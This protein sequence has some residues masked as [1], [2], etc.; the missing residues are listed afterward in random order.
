[1]TRWHIFLTMSLVFALALAFGQAAPLQASSYDGIPASD[2]D[3]QS[4]SSE[5]EPEGDG[6]VVEPDGG[7]NQD[8][9]YDPDAG[10]W[11]KFFTIPMSVA[12]GQIFT[13]TEKLHVGGGPL[14]I[15]PAWY[16]YHEEILTPGWTWN[17]MGPNNEPWGFTASDW[18]Y[19][20]V[21]KIPYGNTK[22]DWTFTPPLPVCTNLTITKYLVYNGPD[23]P[24]GQIIIA[25]YPTVPEP[26]T[27][28]L[29][30][31]AGL[32]LLLFAWR[33]RK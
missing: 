30:A 32:G 3:G 33:R 22:V 5:Y 26:G 31:T 20:W 6:W 7:G 9:Y 27:F 28:V 23:D 19:S 29:L 8:V 21:Y 10:P 11:H 15:A 17:S 25:Q 24:T 18:D 13:L 2:G 4:A 14:D 1:M 12:D 16:D